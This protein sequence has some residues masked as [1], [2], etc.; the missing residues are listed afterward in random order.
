MVCGV[1]YFD[2]VLG[3]VEFVCFSLFFGC[4]LMVLLGMLLLISLVCLLF[5]MIDSWGC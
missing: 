5:I 3:V 1:G 4:R 2:D